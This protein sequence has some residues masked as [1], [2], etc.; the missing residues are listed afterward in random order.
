MNP[1]VGCLF[2]RIY[3]RVHQMQ[4]TVPLRKSKLFISESCPI[5]VLTTILSNLCRA[6]TKNYPT[7]YEGPT[8]L[9]EKMR[10]E[11]TKISPTRFLKIL[12][13]YDLNLCRCS[14]PE[15]PPMRDF[16]SLYFQIRHTFVCAT[17]FRRIKLI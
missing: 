15:L 4:C 8:I 1:A 11:N 12:F 3:T 13:D 9:P 14:N 10:F 6:N 2:Y 17:M 5:L 7:N 16:G